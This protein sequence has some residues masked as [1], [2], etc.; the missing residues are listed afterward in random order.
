MTCK[1]GNPGIEK[2]LR[3]HFCIQIYC[4]IF[5][6]LFVLKDEMKQWPGGQFCGAKADEWQPEKRR[7]HK[8]IMIQAALPPGKYNRLNICFQLVIEASGSVA[9]GSEN[10][11][12]PD[13]QAGTCP[14]VAIAMSM[15]AAA[16]SPSEALSAA[17]AKIG[18]FPIFC[19]EFRNYY[20][21]KFF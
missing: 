14:P 5:V 6:N 11:L 3:L 2:F 20:Q 15:A 13:I 9:S 21:L 16:L 18:V 19:S 10:R 17:W 12:K 7:L 1:S 8:N 4:S